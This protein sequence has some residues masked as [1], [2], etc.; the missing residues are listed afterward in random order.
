MLN[1]PVRAVIREAITP[2][3]IVEAWLVSVTV[4]CIILL[5]VGFGT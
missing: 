5:A 1:R 2:S 3:T 4:G